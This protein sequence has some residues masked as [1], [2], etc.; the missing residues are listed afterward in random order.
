MT[1]KTVRTR[2]APSPTGSPHIGTAF[3]ALA[4]L[5]FAKQQQGQFIVRIEDTDRE[6]SLPEHEHTIFSSLKWLGLS[7]DEG[8]DIGGPFAPYRQSERLPIYQE[9]V[10]LLLEKEHAFYCFCAKERLENLREQ[11]RQKGLIPKYDGHCLHLSKEKVQ[12]KLTQSQDYVVR[13]KIPHKGSCVF[14]DALRGEI[15]IPWNNVDMQ[16]LMKADGFPTYHL[17]NVV[18][19]HLMQ[20]THVMRGEE[21]LSS[22]P[23]HALLYQYFGFKQPEI[24]HLPLLRN[25]DR[26]KLSKRQQHTNILWFKEMGYLPE[27]ILNQLNLILSPASQEAQEL[28]SLSEMGAH[29]NL[30][31]IHSKEPIFDLEKLNWLNGKWLRERLSVDEFI[32][33]FHDFSAH[34]YAD[35]PSI[36]ALLELAKARV[37]CFNEV[38]ALLNSVYDKPSVR[39]ADVATLIPLTAEETQTVLNSFIELALATTHFD[40]TEIEGIFNALAQQS[41]LSKRK[42]TVPFYLATQG[43]AQGLPVFKILELLGK[44][45]SIARARAFY[46]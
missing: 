38:P 10:K 8:A 35:K 27:A 6:R 34:A 25:T 7:W 45:E 4:N 21:W 36:S 5:L 17:A 18:D 24:T 44:E 20:I 22:L 29:F 42:I 40:K 28:R 1:P 12:E 3:I 41:S 16:I 26:T 33:R 14:N 39:Y 2:I 13:M 37:T 31:E 11:Q 23:K 32:T 30:Y 9:H 43:H 15:E 19:D 46:G